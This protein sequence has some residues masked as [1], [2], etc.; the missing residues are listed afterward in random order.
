MGHA[1]QAGLSRAGRIP[2]SSGVISPPPAQKPIPWLSVLHW[3]GI[4]RGK[5][6]SVKS[7]A[8]DVMQILTW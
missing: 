1:A 4:C 8:V 6:R 7:V 5:K 3:E 2:A